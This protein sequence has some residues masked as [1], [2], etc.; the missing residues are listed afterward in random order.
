MGVCLRVNHTI[1]LPLNNP[2]HTAGMAE[3]EM[4]KPYRIKLV[5]FDSA[6]EQTFCF[7]FFPPASPTHFKAIIFISRHSPCCSRSHLDNC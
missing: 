4:E 5:T 6:N 7:D 3:P 2:D 1:R